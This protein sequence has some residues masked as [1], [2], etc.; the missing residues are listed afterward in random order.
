MDYVIKA[1][2]QHWHL[3]AAHYWHLRLLSATSLMPLLGIMYLVIFT[4]RKRPL[5]N[6]GVQH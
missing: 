1:I 6:N 5:G 2:V 4:K 3:S